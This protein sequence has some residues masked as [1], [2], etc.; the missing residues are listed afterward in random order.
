MS[1]ESTGLKSLLFRN[2]HL[3]VLSIL[4]L[5]MA[6]ASALSNL[7]RIEDPRITTRNA[8]V[9]TEFPGA[10]AE[11]V[12]AL[13]TK[14]LEDELREVEAI[15]DIV[16]TSRA[17]ISVLSIELI[18]QVDKTTNQQAFSRIRDRLSDAEV[19][20]PPG[21]GKPD[22]DDERGASAFAML[23][24]LSADSSNTAAMGMLSRLADEL[25]DRFRN[26][27]GAE[28][29]SVYGE[30]EEEISIT[31][32]RGELAAQ[33][34]S[35]AQLA[36]L[37]ASADPK[38]SA[39][40][41]RSGNRDVFLEVGGELDS[42]NRI[43]NLVLR[44]GD[45]GRQLRLGDIASVERQYREPPNSY[46]FVDGRRTV[47]VAV[48]AAESV[49]IDTWQ[50]AADE[51]LASFEATLDEGIRIDEVFRQSEYTQER[52]SSL[53]ASLLLGAA[54]VM[55]VVLLGLGWRA[56]LI[57][58]LALPLSAS[59]TLFGFTFLGQQIHQMTIFGMIIAIG[60]L[61]DNAIVVTDEIKKRLLRGEDRQ[62][63]VSATVSHLFAPLFA[64]T[65]T[66]ILGFMPIFLLPGNTGDFVGPIAVAVVLALAASFVISLTIIAALA[67]RL[68]PVARQ[69]SES[70]WWR[71]GI[72]VESVNRFSERLLR[73][74]FDRPLMTIGATLMLPVAG[75]ILSG[76]LKL[77]F[78]PPADRDQFEVQVW[79][80]DQSS[81][82]NTRDVAL[83]VERVIREQ[84]GV[85]QIS[86]LVGG[87][88]PQIYYNRI[89]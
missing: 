52:L 67:G 26:L 46:G 81:L 37:I 38:S 53:S 86:W 48:A 4:V 39:G 89:M 2:T 34:L 69:T 32:S 80:P 82:A 13:V 62:A 84:D 5:M 3:L 42:T 40:A 23:I 63:A 9:I 54:V 87:S 49:R 58:G 25:A 33:G 73:R 10:S 7:P 20:L 57:V 55:M 83:G 35:S 31:L 1:T 50:A 76:T 19:L 36:E 44:Q 6:G 79:M 59:A 14:P 43:R 78:F 47:F 30:A 27:S 12:E 75:F 24:G 8:L 60:L 22:F 41:L 72:Q 45:E 85:Q 51:V 61:I 15:K 74:A 77:Q 65:L 11:R 64:S 17:N 18:D 56:A 71:D 21:A 16:S 68:L 70:V 88:H 29:V 28:R 66:T